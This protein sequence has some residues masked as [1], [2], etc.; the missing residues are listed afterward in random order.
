MESTEALAWVLAITGAL[1]LV[2]WLAS[3]L[4]RWLVRR[5]RRKRY[6]REERASR[7][8]R[9]DA[10]HLHG[11]IGTSEAEAIRRHAEQ[12]ARET[13]RRRGREA[14]NPHP[15]GTRE[16]VLWATSYHLTLAELAE[17]ESR[18]GSGH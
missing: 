10:S 17:E 6:R 8:A 7:P 9:L 5:A 1:L 15:Q 2:A 14:R 13:Q 16:Y 11:R 12:C 4:R 3:A 18:R